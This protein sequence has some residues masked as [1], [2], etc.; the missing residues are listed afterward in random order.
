M[1]PKY[2]I[3]FFFQNYLLKNSKNHFFYKSSVTPYSFYFFSYTYK[4]SSFLLKLAK[5]HNFNLIDLFFY[6]HPNQQIMS[7][8]VLYDFKVGYYLNIF[9]N[10]R[11]YTSNS[12]IY[13]SLEWLEREFQEFTG[14]N[15]M[16]LTDTRNLLLDYNKSYNPLLK[17]F[18]CV[19]FEEVYY[20]NYSDQVKYIP[21]NFIEL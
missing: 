19:G 3:N 14:E 6:Q 10:H 1:N 8:Y 4:M 11:V 9:L 15:V 18:P 20:D 16:G 13:F 5:N 2:P 7:N 12:S 17:I 21:C